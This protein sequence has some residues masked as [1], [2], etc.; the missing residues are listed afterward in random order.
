[1]LDYALPGTGGLP[2]C[3][4]PWQLFNPVKCMVQTSQHAREPVPLPPSQSLLADHQTPHRSPLLHGDAQEMSSG[5][6][7][8]NSSGFKPGFSCFPFTS[9]ISL[10]LV[11][12]WTDLCGAEPTQNGRISF[13]ALIPPGAKENQ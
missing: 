9:P 11:T 3:T 12:G 10:S 7:L 1:M 13:W 6:E 4:V 5:S 2:V 8:P